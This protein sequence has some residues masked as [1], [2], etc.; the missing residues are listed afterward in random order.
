MLRGVLLGTSLRKLHF[1]SW[2][3]SLKQL[4]VLF[5][6]PWLWLVICAR[7]LCLCLFIM[8]VTK[9]TML[10]LRYE[11][12]RS[13]INDHGS[14]ARQLVGGSCGA[15][16]KLPGGSRPSGQLVKKPPVFWYIITTGSS[17]VSRRRRSSWRIT[18][19]ILTVYYWPN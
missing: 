7:P 3:S 10:V 11:Q 9:I 6:A 15:V 13:K 17:H 1:L 8:Q 19:T 16:S 14:R 18:C 4:H 5:F 2:L 12:V